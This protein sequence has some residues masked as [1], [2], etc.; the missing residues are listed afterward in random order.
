MG[1]SSSPLVLFVC[2]A[3]ACRSPSAAALFAHRVAAE[4]VRSPVRVASA[5]T[6]A[7]P[8]SP[9]C[10]WAKTRLR[11]LGVDKKVI[12]RGTAQPITEGR[13]RE[14]TLILS[15]DRLVGSQ[16][17][18]MDPSARARL[19]TL[20]EAA[21]LSRLVL[22]SQAADASASHDLDWLV[23]EL[24]ATRGLLPLERPSRRP[25][26]VGRRRPRH[27]SKR[28][29]VP[30]AHSDGEHVRHATMFGE[31][32]AAC[33]LLS[34]AVTSVLSRQELPALKPSEDRSS[35]R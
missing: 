24:D 22:E 7:V 16:I 15:A 18:R 9:R 35:R 10:E 21:V 1:A 28:F 8:G 13:L 20:K 19:F 4:G 3:N 5:G 25:L 27:W 34:D 29:D 26:G 11:S 32:Q 12:E 31:L 6:D 33:T 23:A 17:I 30:D 14:A 2:V